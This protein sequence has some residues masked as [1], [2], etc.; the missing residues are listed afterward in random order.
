MDNYHLQKDQLICISIKK[1]SD[2]LSNLGSQNTL[3]IEY[4]IPIEL[5]ERIEINSFLYGFFGHLDFSLYNCDINTELISLLSEGKGVFLVKL[6]Y[7]YYYPNNNRFSYKDTGVTG[8]LNGLI[9]LNYQAYF[10][11][12]NNFKD[13]QV[14]I[15][16]KFSDP[17][18]V[19]LKQISI[20]KIYNQSSYRAIFDDILRQY[21]SIIRIE[22]SSIIQLSLN[23]PLVT[24]NSNKN[25]SFY[26]F[27]FNTL[28]HY[29]IFLKLDYL[30]EKQNNISTY[31]LCEKFSD[32]IKNIR[33][34]D[35]SEYFDYTKQY[36]EHT[37]CNEI[38][39]MNS[40][41][42]ITSKDIESSNKNINLNKCSKNLITHFPNSNLF[43]QYIKNIK[44][45]ESNYINYEESILLTQIDNTILF[46]S[47]LITSS[48]LD[49][50]EYGR[51]KDLFTFSIFWTFERKYSQKPSNHI[52][53]K[54]RSHLIRYGEDYDDLK[55]NVYDYY[56]VS[57]TSFISS[58]R[59]F[60][61]L[62][63]DHAFPLHHIYPNT[64][65]IFPNLEVFG[66]IVGDEQKENKLNPAPLYL[67]K[68]GDFSM[69]EAQKA[70]YSPCS[71]SD[72]ST[73][74]QSMS[75]SMIQ[76]F[77]NNFYYKIK[78]DKDIYQSNFIFLPCAFTSN[79]S[80]TL[81]R[82]GTP[83][84]LS[85]QQEEGEILNPLWV[86]GFDV[87]DINP[88][89]YDSLNFTRSFSIRSKSSATTNL[90]GI[91]SSSDN[92]FQIKIQNKEGN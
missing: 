50:K 19:I 67:Y 62:Q 76:N 70:Q 51:F 38:N 30:S 54:D 10:R 32:H 49:K 13:N 22:G 35:T 14:Q 18:S 45:I 83:V 57:P 72:M 58:S 24:I 82:I 28:K 1:I 52:V 69:L 65:I 2:S 71:I 73:E 88:V 41:W 29:G 79:S 33:K 7:K 85:L 81:C 16:F 86:S 5:V 68:D 92:N 78:I 55:K 47:Y 87:N 56:K 39:Y 42:G 36:I 37:S 80:F 31:I 6:H 3:D 60:I 26:D 66:N 12:K 43:D 91:I 27:F 89:V 77:S 20:S 46:P 75:T 53:L 64:N 15:S 8:D 21:N 48:L 59:V 17:L 23:R 40:Y 74:E 34:V 84:K 11:I 61:N 63:K 90:Y 9:D 4:A 44:N 25:F